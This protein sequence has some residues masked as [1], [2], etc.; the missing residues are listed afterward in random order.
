MA[1]LRLDR[2][3]T[4]RGLAPSREKARGMILAG[5]VTVNGQRV[6][7]AGAPI[8]E[9]AVL[10]VNSRQLRY[11][12]RGGLKLEGAIRD[13]AV[14]FRDKT[15]IDVGASTG[16]YT[17]CAL[18][19]GA[20][21]VYAI[22]VGYGQLDWK[23]RNDERVINM[24]RTNIRA[25]RPAD[26]GMLADI[27]VMDVSFISTA[28]IFPVLKNLLKPEGSVIGLIKPQFEAGREQVGKK[29]VV[30]DPRVHAAVL[31]KCIAAAA[32]EGLGCNGI[33]PSPLRG[34]EGNIEFFILLHKDA[35]VMTEVNARIGE[36]VAAAHA[37][38]VK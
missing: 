3:L 11:V 23:L 19:N 33:T 10:A 1:R 16:G 13:F 25:V 18:Q 17:D 12:S 4:E 15:V 36:V 21:R 24:E 32:S 20:S 38:E 8:S 27:I 35:P 30:R 34:P 5:E 6:D 29:G 26:I 7:K 37:A 2:L 28:L 22:D 9:D 14:D 31:E